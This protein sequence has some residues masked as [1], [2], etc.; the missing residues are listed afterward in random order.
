MKQLISPQ[1]VDHYVHLHRAILAGIVFMF[2]MMSGVDVL[3]TLLIDHRT[4]EELSGFAFRQVVRIVSNLL[5][6]FIV[7]AAIRSV[8]VQMSKSCSKNPNSN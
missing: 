3:T 7:S 4:A 5:V 6:F 2:V 8:F 1:L